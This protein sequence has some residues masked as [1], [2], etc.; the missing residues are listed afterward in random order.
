MMREGKVWL[1]LAV[2]AAQPFPAAAQISTRAEGINGGTVYE[3]NGSVGTGAGPLEA[4]FIPDPSGSIKPASTGDVE[5]PVLRGEDADRTS[6]GTI[7]DVK[8]CEGF[9]IAMVGRVKKDLCALLKPYST[10]ED[11]IGRIAKF[12]PVPSGEAEASGGIYY[13]IGKDWIQLGLAQSFKVPTGFSVTLSEPSEGGGNDT[14][15]ADGSLL[16]HLADLAP[17]LSP[18]TKDQVFPFGNG[19]VAFY[20]GDKRILLPPGYAMSAKSGLCVHIDRVMEY[21][22]MLAL[23]ATPVTPLTPEQIAKSNQDYGC[24]VG[25]GETKKPR[26]WPAIIL[27]GIVVAIIGIPIWLFIRSRKRRTGG[28]PMPD[29]Y[30]RERE[31]KN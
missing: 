13:Q 7:Y 9:R 6:T 23:T 14:F 31:E 19:G 8:Q 28:L 30:Y 21:T 3:W 16:L 15:G 5:L 17:P 20:T 25:G 27:L 18:R 29:E 10:V 4:A 11:R 1:L 2:L 12:D 22:R 26:V 24:D